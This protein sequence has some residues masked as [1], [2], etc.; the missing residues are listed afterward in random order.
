MVL[1]VDWPKNMQRSASALSPRRDSLCRSETDQILEPLLKPQVSTILIKGEPGTGKTTLAMELLRIHGRGTYVSTR[2]S[3]EQYSIQLPHLTTLFF[4]PTP[5]N[6]N[7]GKEAPREPSQYSFEDQRYSNMTDLLNALVGGLE[8]GGGPLIVLDSWD[9]IANQTERTERL[10]V[11]QTMTLL[12]LGHKAKL[13]FISEEPSLTTT[14]YLVDAVLTLKNELFEGRRVR[15]LEWNKLRGSSI[16]HWTT[17]YTLDSGR[18]TPFANNDAM[19]TNVTGEAKAFKP[20]PHRGASYSTGST[21]LD[22]FF[23]GGFR[24]GITILF[25]LG[26]YVGSPSFN[27]LTTMLRCNF[28]ANGGCNT[29][30]PSPGLSA[31]RI[32]QSVSRYVPQ[33]VIEAGMRIGCFEIADSGPSYFELDTHD[34]KKSLDRLINEVQSMK[35]GRERPCLFSFGAESLEANFAIDDVYHFNHLLVQ[36]VRALGDVL[37]VVVNSGSKMIDELSRLSDYHVKIDQIDGT[38]V[39]HSSKPWSRLFGLGFDYSEGF[40][41]VRLPPIL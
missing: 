3:P 23:G 5:S 13:V 8:K 37:Y 18:F 40:P 36:K 11:E 12:A 32:V 9:A 10:K 29:T 25:E 6:A 31:A 26:R 33:S 14:D 22:A 38:L 35:N 21:D 24:K 41:L 17:L 2:V 34:W 4:N 28:L 20:T 19:S 1:N 30:I 16:P 39:I 7:L 15:K 27:P